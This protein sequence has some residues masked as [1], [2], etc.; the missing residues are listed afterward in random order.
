M[1]MDKRS[2]F[3]DPTMVWYAIGENVGGKFDV[4]N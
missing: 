2:F 3:E 4:Y 1:K